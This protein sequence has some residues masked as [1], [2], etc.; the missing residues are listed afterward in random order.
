MDEDRAGEGAPED[1]RRRGTRRVALLV[2]GA[3][4]ALAIPLGWSIFREFRA[5]RDYVR[6]TLDE[7]E[8]PPPWL[9]GYEAEACVGAGLD[10]LAACQGYEEFCR[11]AM[12]RV[13]TGCLESAD[14]ALWCGDHH[15]ELLRTTFG[16]AQC[17]ERVVAGQV[18]DNRYGRQRCA[19]AYRT[20]AEWCLAHAAPQAKVE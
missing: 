16:Y 18:P 11:R 15:D 6:T 1:G 5:F 20:A 2:L 12:P 9:S 13:I 17:E 14:R 10:W 8:A 3:F 4:L 19:L 7:P